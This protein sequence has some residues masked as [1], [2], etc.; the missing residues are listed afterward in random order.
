MTRRACLAVIPTI[1]AAQS[2][3]VGASD[4]VECVEGWRDAALKGDAEALEVLLHDDLLFSHSDGRLESKAQFI[5]GIRAKNPVYEAIEMGTQTLLAS[6]GVAIV[7]GQ[8]TVKNLRAGQRSQFHIS[9]L[10]VLV[11]EKRKWRMIARQATR[12]PNQE[13]KP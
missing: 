10:H 7:R 6:N 3:A 2:G 13:A 1:L 12:L 11:R 9:V 4:P 5:E 8:M